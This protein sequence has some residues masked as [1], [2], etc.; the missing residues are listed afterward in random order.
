MYRYFSISLSLSDDVHCTAV[1]VL[2]AG[3]KASV[4]CP[5]LIF[6]NSNE[7]RFK[8]FL[9]VTVLYPEYV[10]NIGI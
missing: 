6:T 10:G 5:G 4:L 8:R 9:L 1:V 7:K 2:D 3:M